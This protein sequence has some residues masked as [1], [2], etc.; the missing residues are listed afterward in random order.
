MLESYGCACAHREYTVEEIEGYRKGAQ[1]N[2]LKALA[3]MEEYYQWREWEHEEG[4]DAFKREKSARLR[5]RAKRLTLNDP[6]ALDSEMGNL[7]HQA[8]FSDGLSKDQRIAALHKARVYA[9]RLPEV[10][11]VIDLAD[12]DRKSI[13][14]IVLIDRTLERM[15]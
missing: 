13:N 1:R 3:Q 8:F 11:T 15:N 4:T 7:I 5:Y 9:L 12:Q 6:E 14:A 2:D 10:P